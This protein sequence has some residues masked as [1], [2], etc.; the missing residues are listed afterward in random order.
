MIKKDDFVKEY[1][2]NKQFHSRRIKH[3]P[4]GLNPILTLPA[5]K[6]TLPSLRQ[7]QKYDYDSDDN[8]KTSFL[9]Q[10]KS[11]NTLQE[12]DSPDLP[13]DGF[14]IITP[15]G[16]QTVAD[17][18]RQIV[19]AKKQQN[20]SSLSSSLMY[21]NNPSSADSPSGGGSGGSGGPAVNSSTR[22][23]LSHEPEA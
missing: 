9:N 18:R 15:S 23:Q 12:D 11:I 21:I 19:A 14:S 3:A 1:D 2:R 16:I 5:R 20:N 6:K 22:F 8:N 17:F 10:Y 7:S 4:F 13:S